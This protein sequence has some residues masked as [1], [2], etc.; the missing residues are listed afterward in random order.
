MLQTQAKVETGVAVTVA[1]VRTLLLEMVGRHGHAEAYRGNRD[2][3]EDPRIR[4]PRYGL[5]L[6]ACQSCGSALPRMI[7]NHELG[8]YLQERERGYTRYWPSRRESRLSVMINGRIL[9]GTQ[10][11]SLDTRGWASLDAFLLRL[12]ENTGCAVD[13]ASTTWRLRPGRGGTVS[14]SHP[15][16]H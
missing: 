3:A 5:R 12:F 11:D 9:G 16:K 14:G 8:R 7:N 10:Q 1:V 15:K 6:S 4:W 13:L 2:V